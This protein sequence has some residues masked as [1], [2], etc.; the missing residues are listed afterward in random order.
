M[1]PDN[2]AKALAGLLKKLRGKYKTEPP[3][4]RDPVTQLVVG[5]L[6]WEAGGEEAE[7][8]LERIMAHMVDTNDLRISLDH[9]IL[10]FLGADYP[11]AHERVARMRESLNEVYRREHA[12]ELHSI[13]GKSKKDQRAYMDSL[14]GMT[15]YVSALVMLLAYGAHAMPVDHKLAALLAKEGAIERGME[16]AEAENHLLRHIRADDALESHQLLQA[17]SDASKTPAQ[18]RPEAIAEV[19]PIEAVQSAEVASQTTGRRKKP[20]AAKPTGAGTAKKTTKRTTKKTTAAK[21]STRRVK[22]K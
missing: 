14:P 5:F 19:V 15:P 12:M 13:S 16:P 22:K 17:W 20:A 8:A 18:A 11:L 6:Q 7:Q 4:P 3:P 10:H 9:E 2:H 21:A 1:K